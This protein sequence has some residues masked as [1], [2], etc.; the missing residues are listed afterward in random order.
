[1]LTIRA[2]QI[3]VINFN[4]PANPIRKE[5]KA[6]RKWF[7]AVRLMPS[8]SPLSHFKTQM[9][10]A[11]WLWVLTLPS[12]LPKPRYHMDAFCLSHIGQ[13]ADN[14]SHWDSEAM[15]VQY[16]LCVSPCPSTSSSPHLPGTIL[17]ETTC[18][19]RLEREGIFG[20]SNL[21]GSFHSEGKLYLS[22]LLEK[23]GL[24]GYLH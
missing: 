14:P 22:L 12:Q 7:E 5:G 16:V 4:L 6:V 1:M 20:G 11:Q 8:P 9:F 17:P 23:K 21:R 19:R 2:F 13:A 3:R 10:S 15:Y 18:E 24:A